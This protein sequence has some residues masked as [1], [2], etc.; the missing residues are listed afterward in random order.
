MPYIERADGQAFRPPYIIKDTTMWGFLL[1]SRME[2]LQ[3][4]CDRYLNISPWLRYKPALPYTVL[5]LNKIGSLQ[6]VNSPDW[7][8]GSIEEKEAIFWILLVAGVQMGPVF[9]A[10][11]FVWFVPYLLIDNPI[12]LISGRENYGFFKQQASLEIPDYDQTPELFTVDTLVPP[13]SPRG[14]VRVERILEVRR[15]DQA[16]PTEPLPL[17]IPFI[18]TPGLPINALYNLVTRTVPFVGMRQLRDIENPQQAC[19]QAL[20]EAPMRVEKFRKGQVLKEKF[21]IQ[22][23]NFPNLP[24]VSA[25]GLMG[26]SIQAQLGFKL[27]FDFRLEL[28]KKIWESTNR[29]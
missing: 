9:I 17:G 16:I 20:I 23:H 21:L 2:S 27:D 5:T 3:A 1:P 19:Y 22:I 18:P 25:L 4:L 10:E 24:L 12:A 13:H 7:E 26:E 29:W 6:S 15:T 28:G 14:K 8:K 11:R